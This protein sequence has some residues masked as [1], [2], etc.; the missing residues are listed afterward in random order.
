MSANRNITRS[1]RGSQSEAGPPATVPGLVSETFRGVEVFDG[2][3]L[4]EG[5]YDV[6]V[7]DGRIVALDRPASEERSGLLC[8]GL[9]DAHVHLSFSSADAVVSGG[10]TGVLDLGRPASSAFAPHPPL[11]YAAAGPLLT[12]PGGYPTRSWGAG[13]YGL[14]IF[15]ETTANEAVAALAAEG[16]A[17]IKVAVVPAELDAALVRAIVGAA[18]VRNL[19]VA[20]HALD[21]ASVR[22]AFEAGVTVL[23]HTPVELL[24]DD[25]VALLGRAGVAVVSTVRAFGGSVKTRSNLAALAAAGCP[26]V[27]GTD[28]GNAGIRP[29]ADADELAILEHTLGSRDAALAAATSGAAALTG[30]PGGRIAPGATADLV[31]ADG[32]DW[33]SI[34]RPREVWIEGKRI[35]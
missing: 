15:D 18:R 13:G 24:P 34:A 26:V 32:Y 12:A 17:M 2:E 25:L 30:L 10:V 5:R 22:L 31:L 14:E 33:A 35:V 21:A 9:I 1:L 3:R 29:G 23:A 16:A 20:A 7:S 8:P 27:Y 4:L 6:V 28:L 19:P 11:R